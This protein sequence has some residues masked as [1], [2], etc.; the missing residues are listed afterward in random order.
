[1]S[2]FCVAM[3]DLVDLWG[4]VKQYCHVYPKISNRAE[5]FLGVCAPSEGFFEIIWHT[6]LFSLRYEATLVNLIRDC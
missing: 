5:Q 2:V 1:M 4:S 6:L 3:S